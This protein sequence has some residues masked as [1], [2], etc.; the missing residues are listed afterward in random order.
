PH[1]F[2]FGRDEVARYVEHARPVTD[3]RPSLEFNILSRWNEDR[4]GA[5]RARNLTRAREL[6]RGLGE[7]LRVVAE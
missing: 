6:R 3:D 2:L 5:T 4:F 7:Y 1:T